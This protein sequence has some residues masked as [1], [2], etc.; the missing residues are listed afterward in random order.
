VI[1]AKELDHGFNFMPL[2]KPENVD[3]NVQAKSRRYVRIARRN[4]HG[5][6]TLDPPPDAERGS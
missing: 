3:I 4:P 2:L 6:T 1:V 5:G